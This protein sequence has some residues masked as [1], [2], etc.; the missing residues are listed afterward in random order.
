MAQAPLT[1]RRWTRDEYERLVELGI[2]EREPLELIAGQLIVAEPQSAYHAGSI[3]RA[4][5]AL[6]AALPAGW[7]VSV[8]LPVSL[9]DDSEPEPDLT[10]S[11]GGPGDYAHA[12]PAAP[13]LVV[14]V[15]ESSLAFDRRAKGSVYARACIPEYWI[16]NL[17]DRVLEVYRDPQREATALHGWAYR[18]MMTLRAPATVAA[19]GIPGAQLAVA[20]LLP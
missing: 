12:H 8:Q 9:D 18:S 1:V 3:R 14:E 20:D 17:V 2:F 10:I 7:V 4:D 13:V 5:Y 16:I 11:V 15:A 19:V 6:R